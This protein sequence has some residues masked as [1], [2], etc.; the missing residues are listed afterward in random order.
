M[1]SKERLNR[2]DLVLMD[3]TMHHLSGELALGVM[4]KIRAYIPVV[5]L[6]GFNERTG[7][8]PQCRQRLVWVSRKAIY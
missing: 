1:L 3:L 8:S 6:S 5:L 4:R 2:F 7:S